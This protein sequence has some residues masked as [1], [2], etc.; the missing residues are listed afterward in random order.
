MFGQGH[1]QSPRNSV[2]EV[3]RMFLAPGLASL[4]NTALEMAASAHAARLIPIATQWLLFL[5]IAQIV[6]TSVLLDRWMNQYVHCAT[7]FSAL[8]K[9]FQS[10]KGHPFTPHRS[11]SPTTPMTSTLV[12]LGATTAP[13]SP[14]TT[15]HPHGP[16]IRFFTARKTAATAIAGLGTLTVMHPPAQPKEF[17]IVIP[18][19]C[20]RSASCP[21]PFRP[22]PSVFMIAWRQ[23]LP[24]LQDS[25]HRHHSHRIQHLSPS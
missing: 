22:S 13:L 14:A 8:E 16:A 23:L 24:L 10:S 1:Q 25:H 4:N 3:Y 12:R 11:F 5:S 18:M 19:T 6:T 9:S 20:K 7:P 21:S 17:S 15:C 2:S